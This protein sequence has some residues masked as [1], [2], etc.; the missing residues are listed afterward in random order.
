MTSFVVPAAKFGQSSTTR[1][2]IDPTKRFAIAS[3]TGVHRLY[4]NDWNTCLIKQ[5]CAHQTVDAIVISHPAICFHLFNWKIFTRLCSHFV[6]TISL[7][8]SLHR[9]VLEA[10]IT[11]PKTSRRSNVIPASTCLRSWAW[12][13][14]IGRRLS[15]NWRME[16]TCIS[17]AAWFLT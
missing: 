6:L 7:A 8:F 3:V 1:T 11:C 15:N 12:K 9:T 17:R 10:S 14:K 4:R 13:W 16:M 5:L 2:V